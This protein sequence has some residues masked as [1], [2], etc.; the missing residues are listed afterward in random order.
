MVLYTLIF[1]TALHN[2]R[3]NI[4]IQKCMIGIIRLKEKTDPTED[5]V[6]IGKTAQNAVAVVSY[7]AE[8]SRDKR[9]SV[10]SQAVADARGISKPLAAKI[11]T[12]LSQYGIVKGSTGPG[13]GYELAI[14]PS[15]IKSVFL[16]K[17]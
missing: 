2:K 14:E 5:T 11:L 9:G 16:W 7:L 13:G 3:G 10:S 8:C 12:T 15:K 6:Q 1:C 17:T 4:P